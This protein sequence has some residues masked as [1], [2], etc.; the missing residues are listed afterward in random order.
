MFQ[1]IAFDE[2]IPGKKYKIGMFSG[3]FIKESWFNMN[4]L[5][6]EFE[7]VKIGSTPTWRKFFSPYTI[8]NQFVSQ[9]PKWKMER[10]SV[11]MI[12]RKLL[13]DQHFEW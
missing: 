3:I 1:R 13:G 6:M 10:R 2:L 9:N 5:Y 4:D 11:N 7:Y 12:V 8:F